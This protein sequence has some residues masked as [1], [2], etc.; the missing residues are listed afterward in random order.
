MSRRSITFFQVGN[1]N[2]T[3]LQLDN[4]TMVFD[5]HKSALDWLRSCIPTRD[6][7]RYIDVLCI[8]HGDVD[9]CGGF[10]ELK[11]EMEEDRLVIGEIWHPNFD[12]VKVEGKDGLPDDY[13]ALRE[14][15]LRRRRVKNPGYGDIE[16]PLR[17]WDDESKVFKRITPPK[18]FSL[19]CLSPYVK[20]EGDTGW[21]V[22]EV[23]L[24]L[25][26]EISSMRILFPGDSGCEIWQSRII[27]LT[28][29]KDDKAEWAEA[30]I[31]VAS[32]HGSF[33]FFGT[34]REAVRDANPYPDNYE[35]LDYI[36]PKIL[37]VSACSRFPTNGDSANEHPPHYAAW[38]WYHR[39]FRENRDVDENDKHPG[40][41]KYTADGHLRLEYDGSDWIWK[42]DWA[43]DDDGGRGGKGQSTYETTGFIYRGGETKR[44]GGRY[45]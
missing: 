27:P 30:E 40:C 39:W 18:D 42:T 38:K 9:H 13:L 16:I 17:A 31:L 14:E 45:A 12:R 21:D 24:V 2:C 7:K 34:D 6:G 20:D 4:V 19:R 1:G 3:L 10:R 36:K 29:S 11:K 32:H 37:V 33:T 23:S 28:L 22:N 44:A 15:V 26:V 41:F 43:P 35:A 5:L 25:R 8:S